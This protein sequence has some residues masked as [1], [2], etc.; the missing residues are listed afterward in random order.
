MQSLFGT[1]K[2]KDLT[3]VISR[4]LMLMPPMDI[5][6]V[7]NIYFFSTPIHFEKEQFGN[8][9]Y[10]RFSYNLFVDRLNGNVVKNRMGN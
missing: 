1:I 7:D 10:F 4:S 3:R 2:K 9:I 8:L 5:S 6:D